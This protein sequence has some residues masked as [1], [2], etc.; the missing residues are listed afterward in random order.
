[1]DVS[2]WSATSLGGAALVVARRI[3][4]SSTAD[5]GGAAFPDGVSSDLFRPVLRSARSL[6]GAMARMYVGA[7]GGALFCCGGVGLVPYGPTVAP[8]NDSPK[9]SLKNK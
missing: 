6:G 1:M 7:K 2:K 8:K 3:S 4:A 5:D 9:G